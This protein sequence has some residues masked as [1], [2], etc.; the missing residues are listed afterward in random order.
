MK[1]LLRKDPKKRD[2]IEKV[3]QSISDCHCR[4]DPVDV[5]VI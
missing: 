5:K 4:V 2:S 3:F 1:Q